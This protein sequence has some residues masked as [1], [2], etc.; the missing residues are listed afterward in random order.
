V[1]VLPAKALI[2]VVRQAAVA[3]RFFLFAWRLL[4]MADFCL[5][6]LGQQKVEDNVRLVYKFAARYPIDSRYNVCKDDYKSELMITLAKCAAFWDE[7][8]AKFSTYCWRAFSHTRWRMIS[9]KPGYASEYVGLPLEG[10]TLVG[11]EGDPSN[12]I[13]TSD[14]IERVMQAIKDEP[15]GNILIA[16]HIQGVSYAAISKMAGI[17]REAARHRASVAARKI[18]LAIEANEGV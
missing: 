7:R 16:H 12:D 9:R 6:K 8:I 10:I 1:L 4:I 15:I 18:R 3:W 2:F 11:R 13:T 14:A 5:T 17:S